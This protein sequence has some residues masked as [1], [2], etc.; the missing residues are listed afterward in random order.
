M[1]PATGVIRAEQGRAKQVAFVRTDCHGQYD[2][3]AACLCAADQ[4]GAAVVCG[5]RADNGK[6]QTKTEAAVFNTGL[7]QISPEQISPDIFCNSAAAVLDGQPKG[8][9]LPG[10]TGGDVASIRLREA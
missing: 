1:I 7:A 8:F 4:H 10:Q 5:R 3:R 6:T 2:L 9:S